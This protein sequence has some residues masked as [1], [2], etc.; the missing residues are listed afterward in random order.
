MIFSN[1]KITGFYYSSYCN[2]RIRLT[3]IHLVGQD[4]DFYVVVSE[5]MIPSLKL[6][7]L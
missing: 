5:S 4:S 7:I 1:K 6:E 3:A 2:S